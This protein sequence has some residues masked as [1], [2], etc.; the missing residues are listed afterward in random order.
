MGVDFQ[1]GKLPGSSRVTA[2]YSMQPSIAVLGCT[3]HL[4]GSVYC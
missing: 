2:R 1:P 3:P 4:G